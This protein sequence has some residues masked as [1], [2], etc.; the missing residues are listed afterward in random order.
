M[1][2]LITSLALALLFLTGTV[3]AGEGSHGSGEGCS[4][5]KWEDT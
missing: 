2:A 5:N 3:S 1:K 4:Y